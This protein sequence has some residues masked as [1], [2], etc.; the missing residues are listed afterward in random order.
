[1]ENEKPFPY[2]LSK[3]E[4]VGSAWMMMTWRA[5]CLPW[6]MLIWFDVLIVPFVMD[7]VTCCETPG[8]FS[9]SASRCFNIRILSSFCRDWILS[10]FFN[11]IKAKKQ[12]SLEQSAFAI[13]HSPAL[14]F[15][16]APRP[17]SRFPCHC[18]ISTRP[19]REDVAWLQLPSNGRSKQEEEDEKK[20]W[21][22]LIYA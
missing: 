18:W 5:S 15:C 1:M 12:D 13:P 16:S 6:L 8:I 2:A 22:N 14:A 17:P 11:L 10:T 19:Y 20:G 7:V 4:V 9:R 21:N 3:S